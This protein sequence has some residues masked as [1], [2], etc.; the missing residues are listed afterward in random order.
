M[1]KDESVK[2]SVAKFAFGS[3]FGIAY[4]VM[5]FASALAV[6][7][8]YNATKY[9]AYTLSDS[10]F[11]KRRQ[12]NEE[13]SL[14]NSMLFGFAA[15][16]VNSGAGKILSPFNQIGQI[17]EQAYFENL[18]LSYSNYHQPSYLPDYLSNPS[19]SVNFEPTDHDNIDLLEVRSN[20]SQR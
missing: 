13:F 14:F 16:G 9:G 4:A 11:R 18:K 5:A 17:S 2:S 1:A 15:H 19:P 3:T 20:Q 12:F 10:Y 6:G 8:I 7:A